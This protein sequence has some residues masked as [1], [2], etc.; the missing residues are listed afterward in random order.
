MENP[1]QHA[2]ALLRNQ[3]TGDDLRRL[4][5]VDLS[6]LESICHHWQVLA[7][8]E[9]KNRTNSINRVPA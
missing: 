9:I 4:P 7:E 6:R 1:A 5:D 2:L 3:M 8:V